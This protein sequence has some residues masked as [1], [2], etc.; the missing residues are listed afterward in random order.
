M[1]TTGLFFPKMTA[2]LGLVVLAGRELYK[3]GYMTKD[4]PNSF[5]RELGA[6]PLNVSEF[7]ITLSL[8]FMY[9]RYRTGPL[10][11]KRKLDSLLC[12]QPFSRI[13]FKQ[14]E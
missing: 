14:S 9:L 7:L 4:G 13:E 8:G 1:L 12:C 10:L 11:K 2:G 3:Y 6:F 5:I